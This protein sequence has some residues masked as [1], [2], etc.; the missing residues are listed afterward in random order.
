MEGRLERQLQ[1]LIEIDKAKN[2]LRQ[3]V[4]TDKS[5]R[6][7]DAEH[8]WHLAVMALVLH[9]YANEPVDLL[10]VIKMLLIHDLVEID[11][12]DTFAYDEAGRRDQ[13]EREKAAAQRI[14]GLLP[15]DQAEELEALWQEFEERS[16]A[17][18][19]FAAALDRLHPILL[20]FYA[21][22]VTWRKHGVSKEQVMARNR[23][24]EEGSTALWELGKCVIDEAAARGY[25]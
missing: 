10:R 1:F 6:E 17:D 12:G 11:A 25:L 9:E 3:S 4:L 5:R 2:V 19:R 14:F 8:S 20:N 22:G 13:K 23:H 24:I 21:Q 18:A 15:K 16:T 7:N